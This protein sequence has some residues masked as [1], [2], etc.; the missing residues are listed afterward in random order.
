M[1]KLIIVLLIIVVGSLIE[2]WV[3]RALGV[4]L[5]GLSTSKR[6]IHGFVYKLTGGAIAAGIWFL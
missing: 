4:D 6:M 1:Q 5:S 3:D 2:S